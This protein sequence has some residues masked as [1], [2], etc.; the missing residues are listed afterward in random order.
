MQTFEA[1]ETLWSVPVFALPE[2]SAVAVP[3]SSL[4]SHCAINPDAKLLAGLML[5]ET[6]V[7][8]AIPEPV[9]VITRGKTPVG[10]LAD[11]ASVSVV[12]Q[13]AVQVDAEKAAETPAGKDDA[14]N[15]TG[16]GK[17]DRRC[18]VTP[19]VVDCPCTN[20]SVDAPAD[21]E[22][23]VGRAA[24]VNVESGETVAPPLEFVELTRK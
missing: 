3:R 20:E 1:Q 14:E 16:T 23:E 18:A 11:V 4:K 17:P 10:A 5:I 12:L 24:V 19:S 8:A 15:A 22:I 21:N 9:P 13:D 6:V 2:E 7:D